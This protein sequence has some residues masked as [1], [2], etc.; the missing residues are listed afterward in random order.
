M[1][2]SAVGWW[3]WALSQQGDSAGS[4]TSAGKGMLQ[5]GTGLTGRTGHRVS[6]ALDVPVVLSPG[7]GRSCPLATGCPV[8]WTM[9]CPSPGHKVPCHHIHG[10]SCPLGTLSPGQPCPHG[11][12][13]PLSHGGCPIFPM[14]TPPLPRGDLSHQL[15]PGDNSLRAVV[16]ISPCPLSLVTVPSHPVSPAVMGG[17]QKE[18]TGS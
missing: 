8:P 6:T 3:H 1:V 4:E 2:R 7:H 5:G 15:S 13:A 12:Q 16:S 18:V 11:P 9:G 14:G 17:W 10:L